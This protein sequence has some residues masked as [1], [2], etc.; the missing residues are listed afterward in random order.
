MKNTCDV[1]HDHLPLYIENMLSDGSRKIVEEHLAQ[2]QKCK[3]RQDEM[4]TW[5]QVPIDTDASPFIKIKLMLQRKKIRT[6]L[7]SAMVSMLFLGTTIAYLTAPEYLPYRENSVT[8][9]EIG[10]GLVLAKFEDNVYDYN[11]YKVPADDQSGYVYHMTTWN[12]VWN[13]VTKK[14]NEKNMILNPDG[15]PV[16][17][18]YYYQADG[19]DDVL[20]YGKDVHPSGGVMTLPRL[21]LSYVAWMAIGVVFICGF[22][23]GIWRRKEKVFEWTMKIFFLPI[24]YLLGHLMIKGMTTSSY[25]STRDFY[26]IVMVAIPLYILILIAVDLI[27]QYKRKTAERL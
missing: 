3:T 22:I 17:A 14:P 24:S 18:V 1:I 7:I 4:K 9:Q 19:N 11:I 6:I 13:R 26:A 5:D 12:S 2:C 10:N 27:R 25:T 16:V 20:M 23:M 21:V 15:E 8:I